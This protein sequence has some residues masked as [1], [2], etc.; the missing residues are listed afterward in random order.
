MITDKT[1]MIADSYTQ[2]A[3]GYLAATFSDLSITHVEDLLKDSKGMADR[4]VGAHTVVVEVVERHL[5]AGVSPIT[6]P[7]DLNPIVS[8]LAAHPYR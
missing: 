2:F 6:N 3:N 5:A 4:L 1:A 8:T 7:D